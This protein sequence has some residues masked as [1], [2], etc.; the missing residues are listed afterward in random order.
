MFI[1]YFDEAGGDDCGFTA[2]AGWV[3]TLERWREFA[4]KWNTMLSLF[5]VKS[6]DMKTLAHFKGQYVN[7]DE[8]VRIQFLTVACR[9]VAETTMFGVASI[10]PHSNFEQV[11]KQYTMSEYIGNPYALAGI[12]CVQKS[13]HW[14]VKQEQKWSVE[15]VFDDGRPKRG[16]LVNLM[17]A[18]G[19]REPIFRS[20]VP[21]DGLRAVTQLQAADFLA[22]EV[23]KV[24]IDDPNETRAIE[25]HRVS[26][27]KLIWVESDWGLSTQQNIEETCEKH[28]RIGK[29]FIP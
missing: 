28:P 20:P 15:F 2:V 3:S 26:L 22:Y 19:V 5:R 29:R 23:R 17:K 24:H 25:K 16:R 14:I 21:R 1:C 9:I 4:E 11:D 13:L 27:R 18:E 7:W 8:P 10:V 6:L 12:T